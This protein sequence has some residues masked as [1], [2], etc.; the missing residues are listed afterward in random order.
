MLETNLKLM[1]LPVNNEGSFFYAKKTKKWTFEIAR[2]FE[3]AIE[4]KLL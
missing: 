4:I 3:D 2:N 1:L